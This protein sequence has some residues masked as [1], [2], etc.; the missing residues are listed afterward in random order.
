MPESCSLF[1]QPIAHF[2]PHKKPFLILNIINDPSH[3]AF[4]LKSGKFIHPPPTYL[5]TL[6]TED[7]CI[8]M[9][10]TLS[11]QGFCTAAAS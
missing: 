1:M 3:A 9:E 11:E 7:T 10:N 6:R 5:K 4:P 8:K 2:V